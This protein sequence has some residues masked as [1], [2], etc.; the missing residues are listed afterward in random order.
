M[1]YPVWL[2][3]VCTVCRMGVKLRC[4]DLV[5]VAV[6]ALL[7]LSCRARE[8]HQL[9]W[10]DPVQ[11]AKVQAFASLPL[12]NAEAASTRTYILRRQVSVTYLEMLVNSHDSQAHMGG[13]AVHTWS[14]VD[15]SRSI[16]LGL[17]YT[18]LA[19]SHAQ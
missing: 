16:Q 8:R 3:I 19:D 15:A 14:R 6:A 4:T 9:A 7:A 18:C 13:S 5:A 12:L 17:L 10:H 1:S 11:I 2:S